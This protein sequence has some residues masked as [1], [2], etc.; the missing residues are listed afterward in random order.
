MGFEDILKLLKKHQVKA[1]FFAEALNSHFFGVDV[2]KN[3]VIRML[4]DKHDVQLHAHPVWQVFKYPDWRTNLAKEQIKDNFFDLPVVEIESVLNE[5]IEVFQQ[6]TGK[7]PI[8]F[9]VGNLQACPLLYEALENTGFTLASNIGLPIFRTKDELLNVEN[10]AALI[11]N[12]IEVPVTS[13]QSMGYRHKSLTITGTSS[14]E[15]KEVLYQCKDR[16]IETVVILAHV[17]E[18]I[19][20]NSTASKVKS[21]KVNLSRLDDLCSFVQSNDDFEFETFNN[22]VNINKS[23][24]TTS[25]NIQDIKTSILSGLWTILENKIND[26]VWIY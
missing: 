10:R 14:K 6:W 8:A 25:K 18:F 9:R 19:K 20:R 11:S 7:R 3:N 13:F 17:H 5:C 1:T 22:L 26:N 16:G 12:I 15:M 24:L 23:T 2:M 4:F 21:N